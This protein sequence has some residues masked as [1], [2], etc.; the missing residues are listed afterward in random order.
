MKL[1][2]GLGNP[3]N[4]Y[5]NTRHNAGFM[6][7]DTIA[8]EKQIIFKAGKGDYAYAEAAIDHD[9]ILLVKPLTYM[10]NSGMVISE[11]VRFYKI[12]VEQILIICD[13]VSIPLG[14]LRFRSNGG[15]G[16]HN[17]LKSV[18]FHLN[19]DRFARLR[20]G[21]HHPDNVKYD[22]ADFVLAKFFPEELPVLK[23]VIESAS[24]AV[25]DY[26]NQG[27]DKAMNKYNGLI[28]QP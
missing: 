5:H 28:I 3:G 6:V 25:T 26:L 13:D 11:L 19:D 14:R 22:L 10:N 1:I 21:V 18:I 16:G 20:I 12:E 7:V 15:D 2:A 8:E 17:G 24:K 27:T 9:R 4:R 23:K